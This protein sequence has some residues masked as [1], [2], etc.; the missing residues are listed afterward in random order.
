[1]KKTSEVYEELYHYTTW[2]GLQRIIESQTLW[3]TN[4]K[5][6]N[7]YSEIILFKEKL[8]PLVYPYV[9]DGYKNL[10]RHRPEIKHRINREG[11]LQK[12]V[13]HDAKGLVDAQYEALGDEIYILS[14]SGQPEK[15]SIAKN[16]L[17]SQWRGYGTGG[18][19]A[20]VFDT[21]KIEEILAIEAKRFEYGLVIMADIVYSDDEQ[22]LQEELSDDLAI[23]ADIARLFFNHKNPGQKIVTEIRKGFYPF[24]RCISR[25]KHYGFSEENEVR[26]VAL[27]TVIDAEYLKLAERNSV[28]LMPE[29][30]RKFRRKEG[31][32][33]PYIELFNS[34]DIDLPIEKIIIGPHKEK[35]IRAADL[36]KRLR[37]TKIEITCSDIP[38]VG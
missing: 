24:V 16:G 25:Y 1:M 10:I 6:L 29:K 2:E 31:K 32:N 11:G 8:I 21:K 19:V 17:L 28:T 5:F 12:V 26:V 36:R 34:N 20:L 4:Y 13:Q 38:Y 35:E 14:F 22:K 30:E 27:P 37:K 3:A 9:L 7:D 23:L 18:G 15:A 33:I